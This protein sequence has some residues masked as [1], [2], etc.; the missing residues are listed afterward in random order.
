VSALEKYPVT[1]RRYQCFESFTRPRFWSLLG[2]IEDGPASYRDAAVFQS[3][4]DQRTDDIGIQWA[5]FVAVA[6]QGMHRAAPHCLLRVVP[7]RP[8]QRLDAAVIGHMVQQ[9]STGR[10]DFAVRVFEAL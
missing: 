6:D 5:F 3:R 9:Q 4:F 2:Q 10:A 8:C 1:F 7:H